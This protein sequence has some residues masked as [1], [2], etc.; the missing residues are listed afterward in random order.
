MDLTTLLSDSI[1]EVKDCILLR[2]FPKD[3]SSALIAV[4]HSMTPKEKNRYWRYSYMNYGI[5]ISTTPFGITEKPTCLT[6]V[7]DA[8]FKDV[9]ISILKVTY[10]KL[11][12][13][14]IVGILP[15][16]C[17]CIY[18]ETENRKVCFTLNIQTT[19]VS[20]LNL[21]RL[22]VS[23]L[24]QTQVTKIVEYTQGSLNNIDILIKDIE[25]LSDM[26]MQR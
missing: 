5:T 7:D 9:A 15:F 4:G 20:G 18:S 17:Y 11:Q 22:L 21:Q 1:P 12:A 14:S 25:E 13:A 3:V 19:I 24:K 10:D 26:L 8:T 2:L 6:L 16:Y 23:T